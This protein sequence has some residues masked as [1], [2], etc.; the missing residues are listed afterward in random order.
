MPSSATA[1]AIGTG[2]QPTLS[3]D[4]Q[5]RAQEALDAI[6]A[7]SDPS[8]A[9]LGPSLSGGHAGFAVLLAYAALAKDDERYR[10]KALAH[11]EAAVERLAWCADYPWLF[12]GYAG[13]AWTVEHLTHLGFLDA[14]EDLNVEI[15]E[16]LLK[17]LR[18]GWTGLPEL[19][20]GLAGVG[21]YAL[22]R[23]GRGRSLELLDRV[24]TLLEQKAER[25][26]EGLAWFDA[27]ETL[28]P[29][30]LEQNPEGFFNLGTS[31]G[32]PG[33]IGF[34]AEVVALG[35]IHKERALT[36]LEPAIEWLLAQQ[37]PHANG[38]R[39]GSGF[40]RNETEKNQMGSR[41]SWCYGDLG[42]VPVLLLAARATGN[43]RWEAAALD[44]ARACA[45]RPDPFTGVNDAG[46]CHGAFGNAHL[47]TRLFQATGESLFLEAA[48]LF[49]RKGLDLRRETPEAAG[50]VSFHPSQ[51][52]E[53]TREPFIPS[54]GLL[55]GAIGIGLAILAATSPVEPCWDRHLMAHAPIKPSVN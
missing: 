35:G 8:R 4:L 51:P 50:F 40:A 18:E 20:A 3:P 42:I 44:L 16:A 45:T 12:A 14:E 48:T 55:E 29:M 54:I 38:S 36:L 37:S 39:Y 17:H 47:F 21:L 30:T 19:I 49:Y 33:V 32:N 34:L 5:T 27:P 9:D 41:L 31:H 24:L 15:D 7:L 53:A 43:A 52:G 23:K 6:L 22:D 1:P 26:P 11:L 10:A 2:W 25:T 46:L 13:V 28:H